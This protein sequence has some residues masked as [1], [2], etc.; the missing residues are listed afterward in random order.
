MGKVKTIPGETKQKE[1]DSVAKGAPSFA[2]EPMDE[3]LIGA[4]RWVL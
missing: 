1:K 2:N 4:D 3:L